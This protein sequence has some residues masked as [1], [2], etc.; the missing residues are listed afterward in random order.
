MRRQSKHGDFSTMSS[1]TAIAILV[2]GLPGSG[3]TYF[4]KRFAPAIDAAYFSSD[5]M[6]KTISP[7]HTYTPREKAN[8]YTALLERMGHALRAAQTVVIDATFYKEGLRNEFAQEARAAN[9]KVI[10]IEVLANKSVVRERLQQKR[11]DSD[12][13]YGVYLQLRKDFEP[14][15]EPHLVLHSDKIGIEEMLQQATAWLATHR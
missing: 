2:C 12:A 4:A 10:W 6:R 9:T 7:D 1:S 11:E 15:R 5:I 14:I 8:V 13:D 3:K